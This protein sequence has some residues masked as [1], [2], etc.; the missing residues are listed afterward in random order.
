[1]SIDWVIKVIVIREERRD[2]VVP[3]ISIAASNQ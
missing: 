2:V 3:F 1:M